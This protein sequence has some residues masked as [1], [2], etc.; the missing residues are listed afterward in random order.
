MC[1]KTYLFFPTKLISLIKTIPLLQTLPCLYPQIITDTTVVI[2][3]LKHI[4]TV[5]FTSS[6]TML[7]AVA[8][9][10]NNEAQLGNALNCY[11]PT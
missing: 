5:N 3:A 10:S 6:E 9:K 2:E 7:T 4:V 8:Q 11:M 1:T